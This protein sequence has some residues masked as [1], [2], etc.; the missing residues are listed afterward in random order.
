MH[1][2]RDLQR[3]LCLRELG[4]ESGVL[5]AE[6]LDF[7]LLGRAA[8]LRFR[9]QALLGAGFGLLAPFGNVGRI[10]ALAAQDS[11]T[12]IRAPGM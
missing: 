4:L 5:A 6:P 12:L 3:G 7:G 9:G 8:F 1:F 11:A 2:S 10:Q